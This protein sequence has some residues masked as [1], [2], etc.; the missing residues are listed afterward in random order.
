MA[1]H[2][3]AKIDYI[4]K[5]SKVTIRQ[6]VYLMMRVNSVLSSSQRTLFSRY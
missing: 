1:V 4:G 5:Q 3:L 2:K 6:N